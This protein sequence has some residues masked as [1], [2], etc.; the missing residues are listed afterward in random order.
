[1]SGRGSTRLALLSL[2][3]SLL[4]S[5]AKG[6]WI[7]DY[8]Q[9]KVCHYLYTFIILIP[10]LPPLLLL[11][12][13]LLLLLQPE[14]LL[15]GFIKKTMS[16][17]CFVEFPH[18]LSALAPTKYLQDEFTVD[19]TLVY[20]EGQTVFAKVSNLLRLTQYIHTYSSYIIY[21][22]RHNVVVG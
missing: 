5:A 15:T 17:G 8:S 21:V 3:Q 13:I 19:P 10:L 4:R 2:K 6:G 16:Y 14:Q 7:Q 22:H 9:L 1:M 12:S 20:S 11:V 18:N